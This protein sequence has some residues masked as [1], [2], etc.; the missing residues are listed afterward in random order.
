MS[1]GRLKQYEVYEDT[2]RVDELDAYLAEHRPELAV[3][4]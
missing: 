4:A 2:R 1:W 3:A